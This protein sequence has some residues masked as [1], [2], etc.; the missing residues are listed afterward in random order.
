MPVFRVEKNANYTTMSNHHLRDRS[1]SLKAKGLLSQFLSLPDSWSYSVKGLAAINKDGKSAVETALWELEKQGYVQRKQSR[2][3]N[4]RL[5]TVEYMIFELPQHRPLAD[6]LLTENPSTVKPSSENPPPEN[7]AQLNTKLLNTNQSNNKGNK[8]APSG[9]GRYQNVHFTPEELEI[10]MQEFPYDY[11]QRIEDLSL[12]MKQ[13][14]KTY[15]NHLAVL[16][17]W[18]REDQKKM[19]YGYSHSNYTFQEGESL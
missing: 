3:K 15:S 9:Y 12:Y 10:L 8:G 6:S 4:G 11:Q 2:D 16:Q 18:A 19:L 13:S 17:R 1:L 7:P 14:G 5:S